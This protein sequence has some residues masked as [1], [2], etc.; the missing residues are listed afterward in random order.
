MPQAEPAAPMPASRA[1]APIEE[2]L[3]AAL[4]LPTVAEARALIDRLDG[5]VGFF[6]IGSQLQMAEG[7]EALIHDLL[8]DGRK[9]FLDF[10]FFDIGET[11][12]QAVARAA[13]L[14]ASFLTVHGVDQVM[15]AAAEGRGTAELK[16]LCVT[17]LT[18]FD[19][20]DLRAAY[21]YDGPIEDFVVQRARR[22]L[23]LGLDGVIA[24]PREARAI[25]RIP[26]AERLLIVTP[27]IRPAGVG[28]DDQ[29]RVA[30]PADAIRA[31]AD[32]LV[33]GRPITRAPDPKAAAARILDEMRAA[34]ED[35]G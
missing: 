29:K 12:R 15:R 34:F 24:S 35:I 27:G 23:E 33:I 20:A 28:A 14:G 16:V 8:A 11:V 9:V 10:K 13:E 1:A 22:A 18:S 30:T 25:R 2:R 6:K 19:A 17:L 21:G 26:G 31:G 3:I 4:D 32:Y 5:T 7:A